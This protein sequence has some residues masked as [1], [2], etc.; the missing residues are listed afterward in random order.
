MSA[1][2]D[3]H[4]RIAG[5]FTATEVARVAIELALVGSHRQVFGPI[6][7]FVVLGPAG[8]VL[9]RASA[10]LGGAIG[11]TGMLRIL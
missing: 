10:M 7:W 1:L 3:E 8:P 6:A 5:E 4:R 9:Y 11:A 2:A